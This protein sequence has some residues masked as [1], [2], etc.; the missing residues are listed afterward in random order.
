MILCFL[1]FGLSA[2]TKRCLR[3]DCRTEHS[4][5]LYPNGDRYEGEF[6]D[7][8]PHGRGIL[9][10]SNGNKHLGQFVNARREGPGK[11]VLRS[12]AE[13]VGNFR[14]DQRSGE[15]RM[16][17]SN[18]NEYDGEWRNDRQEGKGTLAFTNGNRY[19]GQFV[20]GRMEG[21]GTMDYADGRR[22]T[23]QWQRNQWHGLG[24]LTRADGSSAEGEYVY[25]KTVVTVREYPAETA[26]EASAFA[27]NCNTGYCESGPGTY[28]YFT[29]EVYRGSFRNGEPAGTGTLLYPNGDRYEGGWEEHGPYGRGVMYYANGRTTG[30]VWLDGKLQRHIYPRNERMRVE[31]VEVDV[32]PEVKI[33]A[34]IVGV[35]DYPHNK[36][37]KY[38]KDDAYHFNSHL[39]SPKGGA[40]PTERIS[41]LVD[42]QATRAN[43]LRAAQRTLWRADD[44][45]VIIFYFSGHGLRDN[46]LPIDFDGYHNRLQHADIRKIMDNSD[47]KHKLV[48]AD[49]CYSGSLLRAKSPHGGADHRYFEA[50][51]AADAGVA[52]FLSS[53]AAEES[54]ED[55]HLKGGVFTHFL[56]KGMRGAADH[57][58]DDLVTIRELYNYVGRRV[59]HYTMKRQ[60]PVLLGRF[61]D[62]LP[63]SIRH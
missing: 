28:T 32:D 52:F 36:P 37:L 40:V 14:T 20:A 63:V 55:N 39:Q 10:Y 9:Y 48:F 56:L 16:R 11:L 51:E 8:Q 27:R 46:F 62:D 23:G 47:A 12:G 3:G 15:G 30:G 29:G 42:E 60:H 57:N 61:D 4:V 24:R 54:L 35:G 38:T 13:Y 25:G 58:R 7:G 26:R 53:T 2:Q 21:E 6:R 49:A 34:V 43:I 33:W 41:L 59:E 5:L 31:D 22:Y 17:F 1:A 44:N 19:R 18:G 45:D 50:F